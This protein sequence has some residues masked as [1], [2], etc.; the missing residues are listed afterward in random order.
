MRKEIKNIN[1]ASI[2]IKFSFNYVSNV[3]MLYEDTHFVTRNGQSFE[4]TGMKISWNLK[5][6]YL[7][8]HTIC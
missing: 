1:D 7:F 2:F 8:Y 4:I 5:P 6:K 3:G